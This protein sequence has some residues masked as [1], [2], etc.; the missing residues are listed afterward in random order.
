M[1]TITSNPKAGP[2]GARH[3]SIHAIDLESELG[4]TEATH[5]EIVEFFH[6]WCAHTVGIAPGDRVIIATSHRMARTAW[7][8]LPAHGIQRVMRSGPDGADLALIDAIDLPHDSLRFSRLVIGS[9]D[10]IF[11]GLAIAASLQGMLV[12]QVVGRGGGSHA[13]ASVCESIIHIP[14]GSGCAHGL[15][16][17]EHAA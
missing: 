17:M 13:L 5:E 3:R 1:L 10:G 9:G 7:F 11:E 15:R 4:G 6:L 14:F 8:A 2:F 12:Q 16:P